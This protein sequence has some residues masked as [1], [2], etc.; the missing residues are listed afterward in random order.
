MGS[1]SVM[2]W[3]YDS[4]VLEHKLVYE[5]S[6]LARIQ[7]VANKKGGFKVTTLISAIYFGARTQAQFERQK[8]EW[9]AYRKKFKDR[10]SANA[11]IGRKKEAVLRFVKAREKEA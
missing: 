5:K 4:I 3:I 11:Y 7:I 10:S 2:N 1:S 9:V 8:K 6:V